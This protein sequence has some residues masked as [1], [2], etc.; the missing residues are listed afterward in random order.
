[1]KQI[2]ILL[3]ARP[4]HSMLIYKELR[5]QKDITYRFVVFKVLPDWMRTFVKRIRVQ[6][7]SENAI[8]SYWETLK[9]LCQ[10]TF[11]FKWARNF[12]E[13]ESLSPL[14][15]R[16]FK[17]ADFKIIHYWSPFAVNAVEDYGKKHSNVFLLR[18]A[19]MPSWHTVKQIMEPV[20]IQYGLN[21]MI[22]YYDRFISD[23]ERLLKNATNILVPSEYVT[24]TFRSHYNDKNFYVV[25]YGIMKS[26]SYTKRPYIKDGHKFSFVY[27]GGISLEKGCDIL[28]KFFSRHPNYELHV[29]GALKESQRHVLVPLLS[30]NI[31]L[32]GVISKSNLQQEFCKHD[33][34]IHLSR[35]DAYSL[36]VGEI[37]GCGLPVIISET[38]GNEH[39]VRKYNWGLVTNNTFS[40]IDEKVRQITE[41]HTYNRFLDSIHNYL[42]A[43]HDSY[44]QAMIKFYKDILIKS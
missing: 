12:S 6:F 40:D 25:P 36:A 42:M 10:F 43:D 21:E 31:F 27:A 30:S 29:Y 8:I 33:I 34:G 39:D 3:V 16:L 23:E 1:M 35:F 22:G 14:V 15:R 44:G 9:N 2:D 18:D 11:R 38:T 28:F 24:D 13:D 37:L 41:P 4:D 5:A 26:P 20:F 17:K 19:H 7:V 32:H